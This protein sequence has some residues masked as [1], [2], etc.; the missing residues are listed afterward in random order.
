MSLDSQI[1]Y[2]L[3]NLYKEYEIAKQKGFL[4]RGYDFSSRLRRT[5]DA[6]IPEKRWEMWTE[7]LGIDFERLKDILE[8]IHNNGMLEKFQFI[9]NYM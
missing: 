3:E 8:I 1:K 9:P 4:S 2:I 7:E 6:K 5:C